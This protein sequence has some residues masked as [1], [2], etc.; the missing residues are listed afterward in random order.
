MNVWQDIR[1][2]HEQ[3]EVYNWIANNPTKLNELLKLRLRM[4]NEEHTETINAYLQNDS[5]E[6]VDGLIDLIVIAVGTLD[7]FGVDVNE[8]WSQVHN[9]NMN[10]RVGVKPGRP[11]PLGLPDLLK[12]GGWEPPTHKD[13]LGLI[14]K[15]LK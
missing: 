11:N 15:A 8:A 10:K 7:L 9:A 3:Y 1:N 5:E 2:M 12:P 13:N 4:L 6:V 14:D